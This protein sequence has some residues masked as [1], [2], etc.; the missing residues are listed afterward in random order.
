MSTIFGRPTGLF[1]SY[2]A[3]FERHD[4]TTLQK[5]VYIYFCRR[6]N[7]NGQSTPSYDDIAKDCGCHRSSAI[8]AVNTLGKMGLVVKHRR[9][10]HNG[11]DTSNMYVVFPPGSPFDGNRE[12]INDNGKAIPKKPSSFEGSS[13]TTPGRV[14]QDDPRGVVSGDPQKEYRSVVVVDQQPG[15]EKISDGETESSSVEDSAAFALPAS[16]EQ[17]SCSR[18]DQAGPAEKSTWEKIR[19]DVRAVAGVDISVSFAKEIEKN[20]PPEKVSVVLEELDR[21][22][23]QGVEIRGVGAWLRYALE[24]DIQPDQPV[25][26][27]KTKTIRLKDDNN[28]TPRARPEVRPEPGISYRRTPEQ[29]QKRKEF[30][31]SLY[32]GY[33]PGGN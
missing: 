15:G 29:E 9:K 22:L 32:V 1:F 17:E 23:A 5:L 21:Q 8:E 6:A 13:Q 20:Y 31:K 10:R 19:E 11:S 4:L 25:T 16:G 7:N 28:R 14:V 24:N 30:I 26:R 2:D 27:P 3:I 12:V 18:A 33:K